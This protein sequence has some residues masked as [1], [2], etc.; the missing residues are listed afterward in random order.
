M[1]EFE[2]IRRYFV[3]QG[4]DDS[5]LTG[6]GDDGAVLL[7]AAGRAL[8]SVVDTMIEG[9]HWPP[10]LP[11]RDVG[12]RAVAVNVSDIAAMGGTPRWMTL[13][14]TLA[15]ADEAWLSEFSAGLFEAAAEFGV[16]LVG[17]DTTQGGQAVV[18]V[19]VTGDV[20]PEHV[21]E[22]TGAAAGDGIY[23]TGTPGDAAGGLALLTHPRSDSADSRYLIGR[24]S[25]PCI[26]VAFATAL[27][28][29]AS[30]A[31]DLSDGLMADTGKLLDASGAG[32][33]IDAARVPLSG[34]LRRAFGD[35]QALQFALT[36]GD[37]YELCFT[38]PPRGATDIFALAARL[39]IRVTRIGVVEEAV[40]LRCVR[41]GRELQIADPGYVHFR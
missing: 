27:A 11:P 6:I 3:R 38:A 41:E 34:E 37:D 19:Q 13:A 7:P 8:V 16:S 17:G 33:S 30:A 10:A 14:L 26:R 15:V 31:I 24:F 2:I 5:V 12:Y 20:D 18:S 32:G 9:V 22:R 35:P 23:V 1:D 29:F 40:G 28:K 36:G 21:L 25:R 39:G 4:R